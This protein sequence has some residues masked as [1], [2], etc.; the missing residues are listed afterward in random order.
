[1]WSERPQVCRYFL[2]ANS[3]EAC[4]LFYNPADRGFYCVSKRTE[5]P[6]GAVE[7]HQIAEGVAW[8][9]PALKRVLAG[10]IINIALLGL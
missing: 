9:T 2:R 10:R 7:V 1:M 4:H 6:S 3:G 8:D 5:A